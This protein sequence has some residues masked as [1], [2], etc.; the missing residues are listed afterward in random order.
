M[1]LPP[2]GTIFLLTFASLN[3]SQTF[4]HDYG[5]TNTLIT[6]LGRVSPMPTI[7]HYMFN[8]LGH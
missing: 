1:Q 5:L 8:I 3:H 6:S 2:Y 7:R 4:I